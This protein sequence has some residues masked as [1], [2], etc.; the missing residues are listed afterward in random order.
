M[1][2]CEHG[3]PKAAHGITGLKR[4]SDEATLTQVQVIAASMNPVPEPAFPAIPFWSRQ[5][6]RALCN[7]KIYAACVPTKVHLHS[8]CLSVKLCPFQHTVERIQSPS[9]HLAYMLLVTHLHLT[10]LPSDELRKGELVN[11]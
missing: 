6:G 11:D 1:K 3:G 2:Q 10:Y 7:T 8:P 9:D 5:Q 4:V